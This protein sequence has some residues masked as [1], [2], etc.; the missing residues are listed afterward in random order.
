MYE[1]G[2]G[3]WGGKASLLRGICEGVYIKTQGYVSCY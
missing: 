3:E 2:G 1:R